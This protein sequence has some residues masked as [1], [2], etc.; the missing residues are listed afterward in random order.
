MIEDIFEN[1]VIEYIKDQIFKSKNKEVFFVGTVDEHGIINGIKAYAW[2]NSNS[3]PVIFKEAYKGDCVI[4]NHPSGSLEPS[5][6]DIGIAS[7][8]ANDGIG[9]LIVN[10]EVDECKIVV[11]GVE[12]NIVKPLNSFEL[13]KLIAKNGLIAKKLDNFETRESQEVML[14]EICE[15]FNNNSISLIEAGTGTGKS[16]AYLIPSIYWSV[17]NKEKVVISTN[18]INLQEQLMR[19]DIPL[20]QKTLNLD[21]TPILVKGAGNYICL[22]KLNKLVSGQKELIIDEKESAMLEDII[23]FANHKAK[24]GSKNELGFIPHPELWDKINVETDIC[25]RNRCPHFSQCFFFKARKSAIKADILVVNH[26]LLCADISIRKEK[27]DFSANAL[28]PAYTKIIIDEAHN[29]ED[30][31][32]N[33]F[34]TVITRIGLKRLLTKLYSRKR[35]KEKGVIAL[36]EYLI[37]TKENKSTIEDEIYDILKNQ[38]SNKVRVST[39]QSDTFFNILYEYVLKIRTK[40][41]EETK[42]RLTESNFSTEGELES[43]YISLNEEGKSLAK[44]LLEISKLIKAIL[45]KF[46][47]M[48]YKDKE[49]IIDEIKELESLM[50]KTYSSSV[51]LDENLS[52][53]NPKEKVYWV[54]L[55]HRDNPNVIKLASCPLNISKFLQETIFRQFDT[56]AMTSATLTTNKSFDYIKKRI[57]LNGGLEKDIKDNM[58]ESPFNYENQMSICIPTDIVEPQSRKFLNMSTE[59]V[60]HII[61]ITGGS[62]FLL[63]TSFY[64][65]NYAYEELTKTFGNN[66]YTFLKQ[67][68]Y[69]RHTIITLFKNNENAVLLGTDSFWEG[70]DVSGDSL[71]CVVIMRLPFRVPTEPIT[72]ARIEKMEREGINSF[73]E[74]TVPQTVIKFRQGFGRLIRSTS[75]TG[76]V[77]CIDR[78]IVTKSYGKIFLESLPPANRVIGYKDD[79][80]SEIRRYF[81]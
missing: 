38:L 72:Q 41:K 42:I 49:D 16:L 34:G 35:G 19:K 5:D 59:Y 62:T 1:Q 3:V 63:F 22:R 79:V 27:G 6:A 65:L 30:V 66:K 70:V 17:T 15:S 9:F 45:T 13:L 68:M 37:S 4:H 21:F 20:L 54:E 77:V 67:G 31:A 25:T 58:L 47:K 46:Q 57:G 24:N 11:G 36:M 10:N 8:L 44:Q 39:R 73:M 52:L 12:D 26:H 76:C 28:L 53:S 71:R 50:N 60:K 69:D 61:K 48:K 75:D 51:V 33:Y 56:V 43:D 32:T 18:T 80:I 78:R 14:E 55:K 23:E 2:G 81:S 64:A 74:Y 7:K 40:N 29:I